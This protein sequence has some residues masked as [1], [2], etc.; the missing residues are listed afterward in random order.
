[1]DIEV[2]ELSETA[3]ILEPEAR[4]TR[5]SSRPDPVRGAVSL[6]LPVVQTINDELVGDDAA[7][8]SFLAS[9]GSAWRFHLVHL[10]CSFTPGG[11]A[12]FGQALLT[13]RLTRDDGVA[14]PPPIAWSL[15]PQRAERA[16]ERSRTV[17]I[18]AKLVLEM[19][20]EMQTS[21]QHNEVFV[22]SYGLQEPTC[23]WKFT[24]TSLDEISGTQRLALVARTP[25]DCLVTGTVDL[26][27]TLARRRLGMFPYRMALDSDRPL[28][29]TLSGRT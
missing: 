4:V 3:A 5:G 8:R 26:R 23:S 7:L 1:M 11:D 14:E 28:S 10:A 18:G 2:P 9:E 27:A 21:G 6:G 19:A 15:T 25:S 12:S 16:V 22:E 17:K 24:R 20:V 13:V 29:F